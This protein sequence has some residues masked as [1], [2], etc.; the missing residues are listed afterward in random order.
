VITAATACPPVVIDGQPHPMAVRVA[1]GTLPLH[2]SISRPE[3]T[4][5]ADFPVLTCDLPLPPTAKSATVQGRPLAL[6]PARIDRIVVIGDTG[7]RLKGQEIQPCN[8][9]MAYPFAKVAERAAAWKPGAVIHVGDYLYR[10]TECPAGQPGCAGSPWGY[11]WDSWN[12]DFFQPGAPLLRAAPWILVRGNHENCNRAG[13]G[14]WRFLDVHPFAE[15][16]DCA[17]PTQDLTNDDAPPYAVPLGEGA[18]VVV[19]D[20]AYA[21]EA[22]PIPLDDPHAAPIRA[23]YAAIDTLSRDAA[24]TFLATHKPILGFSASDKGGKIKLRPGNRSIQ[25]VFASLNPDLLPERIDALLAGHYHVWEQ[26]SFASNHPSQFIAGFSGTQE[27][28]VPMPETLSPDAS[29]A[30][31]ARPDHFSSWVDGFG[32]MTLERRDARHW[33]VKVWNLAGAVVNT[34]TIDGRHSSCAKAQVR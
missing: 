3:A 18:Q 1:A 34:C 27:D 25:A 23:A 33:D 11:G 5:P 19:M 15:G 14:W 20:L 4:K 6:P 13:Q 9:P 29:P 2:P 32:F 26:V 12:A 30:P 7:C 24:F 16:H 21:E 31:G 28:I 17:D 8:D 10:E 22:K